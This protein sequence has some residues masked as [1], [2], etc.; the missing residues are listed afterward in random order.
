MEYF[1]DAIS[2]LMAAYIVAQLFKIANRRRKR[3]YVEGQLHAS[4]SQYLRQG[5]A[6]DPELFKETKQ[7]LMLDWL[8]ANPDRTRVDFSHHF[9]RL[10]DGHCE[11]FAIAEYL[12]R[13]QMIAS[14]DGS[15]A[16]TLEET[17]H[18]A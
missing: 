2:L 17:R 6:S 3:A 1:R 16:T 14:N 11:S 5:S 12:R 9:D 7:L 10:V 15:M 4:I 18:L 8:D 13:R